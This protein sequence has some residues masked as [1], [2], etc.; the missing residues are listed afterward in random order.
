MA[1]VDLAKLR[2]SALDIAAEAENHRAALDEERAA[3]AEWLETTIEAVRPA[4]PSLASRIIQYKDE[5]EPEEATR[6]FYERGIRL[7]ISVDYALFLLS[8]GSLVM[9]QDTEVNEGHILRRLPLA[10]VGAREAMDR[11]NVDRCVAAIAEALEQQRGKRKPAAD[12]ARRR[13]KQLKQR[14]EEARAVLPPPAPKEDE[15]LPF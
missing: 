6:Y 11:F 9:T 12:K 10:P 14:T 2:A 15:D 7:D 3:E 8:D 13:A 1:E 5:S 4:L